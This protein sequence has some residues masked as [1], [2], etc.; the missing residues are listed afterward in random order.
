[1]RSRFGRFL[2]HKATRLHHFFKDHPGH[3]RPFTAQKC[4]TTA[5]P[6]DWVDNIVMVPLAPRN[7]GKFRLCSAVICRDLPAARTRLA[8]M[9]RR[10]GNEPVILPVELVRRN[11]AEP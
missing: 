10:L 1:M 6:V 4:F 11:S 8:R 7:I 5:K 9:L 2:L 3:V